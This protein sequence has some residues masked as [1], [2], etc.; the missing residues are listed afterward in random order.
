MVVFLGCALSHLGR[1]VLHS[2]AGA[3]TALNLPQFPR[4]EGGKLGHERIG[5]ENGGQFVFK[6]LLQSRRVAQISFAAAVIHAALP[7]ETLKPKIV[8]G[9]QTALLG[10]FCFFAAQLF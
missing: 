1:G 7:F 6:L 3:S 10:S 4:Q 9:V 2:L 8:V 5:P